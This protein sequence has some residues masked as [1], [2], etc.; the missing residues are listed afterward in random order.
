MGKATGH[1][2]QGAVFFVV[3][4]SYI[5]LRCS[6]FSPNIADNSKLECLSF[7]CGVFSILCCGRI[8]DAASEIRKERNIEYIL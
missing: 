3:L 4:I 2:I 6:I 5:I 1:G 7:Y 8:C